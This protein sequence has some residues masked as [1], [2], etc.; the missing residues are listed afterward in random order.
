MTRAALRLLVSAL[1]ATLALVVVAVA[2]PGRRALAL[3]V[4]LL[5]LG[6]LA[7]LELGRATRIAHPPATAS[8][9]ERA[10]RRRPLK[11]ERPAELTR[12]ERAVALGSAN[13]FYL[14]ARLRPLLRR[15]ADE[16]LRVHR[17]VEL[18]TQPE[19]AREALGPEAWDL[20]RPDRPRPTDPDAPG[21]PLSR[22][23]SVVATLERL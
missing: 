8:D 18:E 12:L 9:F 3:D 23:E 22:L 19:A 11:A 6:G 2:L 16:R 4:Y 1:P 21:L 17:G 14:H 15:I 10:L 7:L 13:A 5:F 20:L